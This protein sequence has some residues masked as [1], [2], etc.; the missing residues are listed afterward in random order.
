MPATTLVEVN[1]Q[2]VPL[3]KPSTHGLNVYLPPKVIDFKDT[4]VLLLV[5]DKDPIWRHPSKEETFTLAVT[6]VGGPFYTPFKITFVDPASESAAILAVKCQLFPVQPMPSPE[7]LADGVLQFT[8]SRVNTKGNETEVAK[9]YF[10][11]NER[12]Y[13]GAIYPTSKRGREE[14][15]GHVV[16]ICGIPGSG[17]TTTVRNPFIP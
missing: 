12:L 3:D 7:A 1:R 6:Q 11:L 8:I 15:P 4:L 2:R 10:A 5:V 13:I 16:A 9:G 14:L 17:K